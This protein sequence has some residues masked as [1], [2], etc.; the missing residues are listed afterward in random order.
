MPI[1]IGLVVDDDPQVRSFLSETL[2][3]GGLQ[4][5]TA[6]SGN[7]ALR[8]TAAINPAIVVTDIEMPDGDGVELCRQLRQLHTTDTLKI[9]VVSAVTSSTQGDDA[10]AAGCDAVLAKPCS[11][12]LLLSTIRQLLIKPS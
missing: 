3:R 1:P 11:P 7:E 6:N 10:K 12:A 8:L 4:V 9:I 2:R 5:F